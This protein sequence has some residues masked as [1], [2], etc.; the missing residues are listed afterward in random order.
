MSGELIPVLGI[1]GYV[2]AVYYL[3]GALSTVTGPTLTD[4]NEKR[5]EEIKVEIEQL[6]KAQPSTPRDAPRP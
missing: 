4:D 6:E 5:L 3:F 1:V 2:G